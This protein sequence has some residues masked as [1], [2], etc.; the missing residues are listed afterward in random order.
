MLQEFLHIIEVPVILYTVVLTVVMI[1]L[2][3][4]SKFDSRILLI[5]IGNKIVLWNDRISP[6][7]DIKIP[8]RC[9]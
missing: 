5:K 9:R 3:A 8:R 4:F 7:K 6:E 2:H 1:F